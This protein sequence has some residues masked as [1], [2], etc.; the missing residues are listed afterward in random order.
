MNGRQQHNSSNLPSGR[1][2]QGRPASPQQGKPAPRRRRR[3][4]SYVLYYGAVLFFV[5]ALAITLSLT[6][7]FKITAVEVTGT[8]RYPNEQ[9]VLATG[10]EV[11]DNLLRINKK[12]ISDRLTQY[13]YIESVEVKRAFPPKVVVTITEA[14]PL[15]AVG[16]PGNYVLVSTQG[17]ILET[18]LTAVPD[19]VIAAAGPALEGQAGDMVAEEQEEY[20]AMLVYLREA[21][22]AT[23]FDKITA[24]DVT[25]R[26][27]IVVTYDGRVTIQLG[28]ESNLERKL[29]M[30][31]TVL[32]D[33]EEDFVGEINA[34]SP[35]NYWVIPQGEEERQEGSFFTEGSGS[36]ESG[37]SQE[38]GSSSQETAASSSGE[39]GGFFQ[40]AG[41][42]SE[43]ETTG[44]SSQ[45]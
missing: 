42:S 41:S 37:S 43:E 36:S 45:S 21:I 30:V 44:S 34:T 27:N 9:L 3:R 11:G 5:L 2:R 1:P 4:G 38:E 17:R 18:N 14:T 33:Q 32:E 7:F 35:P 22:L 39:S 10:V 12:A 23:G 6:V 8:D 28:S 40:A 29:A 15:A 16:Q 13:P 26:L 20:I 19:G 25:D 24:V 31:Y